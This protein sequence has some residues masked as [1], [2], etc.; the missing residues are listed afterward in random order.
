MNNYLVRILP[1]NLVLV[2]N[3]QT[4]KRKVLKPRE[5][6]TFF[7]KELASQIEEWDKVNNDFEDFQEELS[8]LWN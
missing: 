7:E 8:K 3:N 6:S 5:I 2:I 1:N 4:K